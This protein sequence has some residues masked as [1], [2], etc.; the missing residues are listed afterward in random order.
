MNWLP[1][2]PDALRWHVVAT[3]LLTLRIG[4]VLFLTPA[5]ALL[6]IPAL[7]KAL[8]VVGL[9]AALANG[10]PGVRG[11][12]PDAT[13]LAWLVSASTHELLLGT[14]L[15]L[16]VVAAFAAISFAGRLLDTQVG[17]GLGQVL[18]PATQRHVPP[19]TM[20]LELTA[21]MVF[22]MLDGHHALLRGI[23][24]SLEGVPLGS[25]WPVDAA[26]PVLAKQMSGIFRQGFTLAAPIVASLLIVELVLAIGARVLP[27]MNVFATGLPLKVIVGLVAIAACLPGMG[28]AMFRI[29]TTMLA[30][31]SDLVA[32]HGASGRVR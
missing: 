21:G 4:P 8:L 6:R 9:A 26:V 3:L 31:W 14:G 10:L 16:G 13:D 19:V 12:A 29:F 30:G 28:E 15:A 27:Q 23:A 11:A 24:W 32:T 1:T 18:D 5:V 7:P 22:L 2:A 20:L 17:F 25:P